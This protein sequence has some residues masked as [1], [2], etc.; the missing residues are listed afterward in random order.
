VKSVEMVYEGLS[1]L[2]AHLDDPDAGLGQGIVDANA[3]G[4]L[5]LASGLA[6][7]GLAGGVGKTWSAT[8][9]RMA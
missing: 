4:G 1:E 8:T 2:P 3:W 7:R 9:K 5:L 6:W